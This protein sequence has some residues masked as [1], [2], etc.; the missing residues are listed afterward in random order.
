MRYLA[1][2][3]SYR[4]QTRNQHFTRPKQRH[5]RLENASVVYLGYF[6]E[7]DRT[8]IDNNPFRPF[9]HT[10]TENTNA[11]PRIVTQ[12]TAR[13]KTYTVTISDTLHDDTTITDC[14]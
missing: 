1:V 9:Q 3:S 14:F 6:T 12:T 8:T 13:N 11:V 7:F 4:E 10:P 5:F 2:T